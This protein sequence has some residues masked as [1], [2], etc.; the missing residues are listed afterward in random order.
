MRGPES[1]PRIHT[2]MTYEELVD[3]IRSLP[4]TLA[5][6]E[7]GEDKASDDLATAL[8]RVELAAKI[9]RGAQESLKMRVEIA[10][11]RGATWTMVGDAIGITPTRAEQR[12]LERRPFGARW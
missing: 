4:G 2:A 7:D 9:A 6:A 5:V 12:Y 11:S 3:Q 1:G 8:A 10:R